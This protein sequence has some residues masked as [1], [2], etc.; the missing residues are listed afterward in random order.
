MP[1]LANAE[2]VKKLFKTT[3]QSLKTMQQQISEKL[4]EKA[5]LAR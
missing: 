3:S 4:V 2:E 5:E 1:K